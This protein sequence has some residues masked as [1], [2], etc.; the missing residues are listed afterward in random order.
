M[1]EKLSPFFCHLFSVYRANVE[2]YQQQMACSVT[3]SC[4]TLCDPMDCNPPGSSVF[5]ILQARILFPSPNMFIHHLYFLLPVFESKVL[6][7]FQA[8]FL[9]GLFHC[10]HP[11][12][13]TQC[14]VQLSFC[15]VTMIIAQIL[16]FFRIFKEKIFQLYHFFCLQL[17]YSFEGKLPVSAHW[18]A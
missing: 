18:L 7:R 11:L 6:I 17:E 14:L 3:Q 10:I 1:A 4:P 13:G 8:D 15:D 2:I 9:A 16:L 5:G 12:R